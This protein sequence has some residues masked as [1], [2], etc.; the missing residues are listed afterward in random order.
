MVSHLNVK[1]VLV[2]SKLLCFLGHLLPYSRSGGRMHCIA[3]SVCVS[4]ENRIIVV[5]E[6]VFFLLNFTVILCFRSV[7]AL[8]AAQTA[9]ASSVAQVVNDL[10]WS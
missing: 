6:T 2:F 4:I 3:I 9:A 1:N 5:A 7:A 8:S 10:P